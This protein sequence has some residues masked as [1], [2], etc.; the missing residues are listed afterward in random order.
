MNTPRYIAVEGVIG[1]GKTTLASMLATSLPEARFIPEH[2]E[3]NPFL[4]KFYRERERYAFQVQMFFLL[5]RYRQQLELAQYDL[6]STTLVSDYAFEKDEIFARLILGDAEFALYRQVAESLQTTVVRPDLIVYLQSDVDRLMA[7]IERRDRTYE[8]A[9]DR[10]YIEELH[11]AY[12]RFFATY[13][14]V[15]V[16]VVDTSGLDIVQNPAHFDAIR[17]LILTPV[18]GTGVRYFSLADTFP[19]PLEEGMR[20]GSQNEDGKSE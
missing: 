15:P 16:L 6:F 18:A 12:S 8:R 20:M 9:I 2:F 19:S 7:N 14:R 4:E 13:T 1:A 3:D 5:S 10:G 11:E 17:T